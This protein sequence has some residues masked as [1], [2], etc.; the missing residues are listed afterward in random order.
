MH[1]IVRGVNRRGGHY[2]RRVSDARPGDVAEQR[3]RAR[4]KRCT[5]TNA[6][7]GRVVGE[8]CPHPDTG[9][10]IWWGE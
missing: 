9:R 10:R 2:M 8:V 3:Y 5:I 4:D 1:L 6:E 7:T